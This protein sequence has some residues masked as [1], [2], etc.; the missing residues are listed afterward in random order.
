M[1][2]IEFEFNKGDYNDPFAEGSWWPS[3]NQT[4]EYPGAGGYRDPYFLGFFAGITVETTDVV[5]DL[6]GH[7]LKM[8]EFFY[9]Y[10]RW[11]SIIE[12]ASQYF[13]PGQ[14]PGF[15]GYDPQYANDVIIKDGILG[16]SSHFGIHGNFNDNV[17]V[18]NVKIQDFETHGM[19]FNGWS[20]LVLSNVDIGPSTR[21]AY[22]KAEFGH[23]RV[24]LPRLKKIYDENPDGTMHFANRDEMTMNDVAIELEAQMKMALD[25]A[26]TKTEPII[27][28]SETQQRWEKAQK[29]FINEGGIPFSSSLTGLFLNLHSTSVFTFNLKTDDYS[30]HAKIENL[31]I[32]D[33][34]HSF[35][36]WIRISDLQE[37]YVNPLTG[38]MD[39]LSMI[40]EKELDYYKYELDN[41]FS[42][43]SYIG[44]A[45]TD[46]FIAMNKLSDNWNY[47]GGMMIKNDVTVPWAEDEAGFYDDWGFA[48]NVD[49]MLHSGKG[50]L[51][52]RMDGVKDVEINGL[53]IYNLHDATPLGRS[54][55][56]EYEG[57]EEISVNRENGGHFRQLFPIQVGFS[58]NMVL[59]VNIVSSRDMK[60]SN[61]KIHDLESETGL[62]DGIA[63]WTHCTNISLHDSVE[64]YNFNA[65][66]QLEYG[67]LSYSDRPNKAPEVCAFKVQWATEI[68][69]LIIQNYNT[70]DISYS[71][72]TSWTFC[73]MQGH[74]GCDGEKDYST[75]S[76]AYTSHC[77]QSGSSLPIL[78]ENKDNVIGNKT[79]PNSYFNLVIILSSVIVIA[80]VVIILFL[81]KKCCGSCLCKG[82][83][84]KLDHKYALLDDYSNVSYGSTENNDHVVL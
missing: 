12:L 39:A 62:I 68:G 43:T 24:V 7:T 11:F 77:S 9:Y 8:S 20:N 17:Q 3:L 4:D 37:I 23:A 74:V 27:Q 82:N 15:M 66:S 28:D 33:L 10:Q 49:P 25:W 14:G 70:T 80:S 67:E 13:L 81:W 21:K 84:D 53:E 56:G 41:D 30:S 18:L 60:L 40:G 16:L 83:Q 58:G 45:L 26:R 48:C 19:Q 5:I 36:E 50:I 52:F 61:I 44:N 29:L 57:Y 31:K 65:G 63:I 2:D 73:N 71:D 42:E 35:Q 79:Q 64:L 76:V 34:Y 51:G 32:H 69:G 78:R 72:V 22:L 46:A 59:A 6:N 38:P 47:L 55:C 54:E 1:E 75:E